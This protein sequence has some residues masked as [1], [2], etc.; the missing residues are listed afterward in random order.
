M[1]KPEELGCQLFC[2]LGTAMRV[3]ISA[4]R[5]HNEILAAF[6][7]TLANAVASIQCA[8]CR[9]KAREQ[10]ELGLPEMAEAIKTHFPATDAHVH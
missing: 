1:E 10:L 2:A 5:T 3:R 7:N 4:G 6:V 9:E 8:S